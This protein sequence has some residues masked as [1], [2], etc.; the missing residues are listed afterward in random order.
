MILPFAFRNTIRL[1]LCVTPI[2]SVCS[3]AATAQL[4][5]FRAGDPSRKGISIIDDAQR[6]FE[7]ATISGVEIVKPVAHSDYISRH[8]IVFQVDAD[9]PDTTGEVFLV[10]DHQDKGIALIDAV[11]T[12]EGKSLPIEAVAGYTALDTGVRRRALFSMP[13]PPRHGTRME[14]LGVN[15]LTGLAIVPGNNPE[16]MES[17]A[18]EIPDAVEPRFTLRR[19]IQ[20]VTTAG[21]NPK[22]EMNVD[23][24]RRAMRELSPVARSLGFTAV[25]SYVRWNFV[26]PEKGRFDWSYYDAIVSEAG[27]HQL[28]WFPLLIVGSAYAL[29]AWFKESDENIGFVCL[30]HG[31]R[32]NIQTIFTDVQAPHVQRFMKAFGEHY[33]PMDALLGVRLGPSGNY[34]ESQYPAGGNWGFGNEREHIHI[35]WWAGDEYAPRHLQDYLRKR[36]SSIDE[37]NS[38]WG[39]TF[40]DFEEVKPSIPQFAETARKRKDLVDWYVDAMTDWCDDWAVWAREAM[41]DTDIYQSTGGWGFVESGTDFTDQTVSMAKVK[42]GIRATNETDSYAQNFYAT[43]MMTSAAR[44]YGVSF[45][46]EPAGYGSARGVVARLYN[47]IV[48]NG[49]HLFYYHSNLL[50]NDQAVGKWLAYAPLLDQR[51]EPF[52]EV[53]ALYPDTMSKLDDAVFR[54]LYAF[55]F[56]SQVAALRPKLDFD[57]CSERMVLDGALPRYKVLMLLWNQIIEDEPLNAIDAWV[58]EGGV[59][60]VA[61]WRSQAVETVD[62]DRSVYNRW[63]AGDTGLGRVIFVPDDRVPPHRM[64]DSITEALLAI[65][66]LDP[67]TKQMLQADKPSEVYVSLLRNGSYAL[68]NYNDHPV[69]VSLPPHKPIEMDSYSIAILPEAGRTEF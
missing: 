36:Y 24:S 2:V 14:I 69:Q 21:V 11:A 46:S 68:L 60:L 28:Q 63:Q 17:V 52:V 47:I 43:R 39:E 8:G 30:E 31:K 62:G 6:P 56:N 9:W 35:G 40:T 12:Y 67:K 48:N 27:R 61:Q 41:P 45:G 32:N 57:F 44:F 59:V 10:V 54:N 5:E 1:L 42:G 26:E 58:R 37:L 22:G 64:A 16:L 3:L 33:G 4:P 29:P 53:A 65:D 15:A 18:D 49:Q 20:L 19:P 23:G 55:T 13:T 7:R 25:E 38:A 50:A 34:G 51:D 66:T